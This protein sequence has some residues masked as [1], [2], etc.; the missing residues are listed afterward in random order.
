MLFVDGVSPVL[1][2]LKDAKQRDVDR[3]AI[4]PKKSSEGTKT[5]KPHKSRVI[6]VL[7]RLMS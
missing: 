4:T 3:M 6:S 2:S 7:L 5:A 1:M